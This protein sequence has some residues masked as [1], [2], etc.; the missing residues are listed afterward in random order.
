MV[1]WLRSAIGERGTFEVGEL[2][3]EPDGEDWRLLGP[4]LDGR[5]PDRITSEEGLRERTRFD[6]DGRYRPL[7]GARSLAGGW[8][9][10]CAGLDELEAAIETVYPLAVHHIAMAASRELRTVGLDDVLRRQSGRYESARSLSS[11]GRD[12][13]VGVVCGTCVREPTWDG[14]VDVP[15]NGI[16]CPEPCSVLVS[17]CREAAAWERDSPTPRPFDPDVRFA[18]FDREGNGLREAFLQGMAAGA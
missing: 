18:D 7:T 14:L 2:R 16:P 8:E 4:S 12:R 13:A 1:S 15:A 6:A 10:R 17:F 9:Y 11:E 3:V 5:D